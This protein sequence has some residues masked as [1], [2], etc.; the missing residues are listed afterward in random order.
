MRL[1][2]GVAV[3]VT[4]ASGAALIPS[5]A[6]ELP[7]VG[8]RRKKG[9]HGKS[10]RHMAT[11]HSYDTYYHNYLHLQIITRGNQG[12]ISQRFIGPSQKCLHS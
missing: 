7:H 3:A 10:S 9:V 8:R 12:V 4:E 5:L 11:Y 6:Q 2:S 1:G